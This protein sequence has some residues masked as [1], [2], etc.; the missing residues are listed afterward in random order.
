MNYKKYIIIPMV[1]TSL[2][3]MGSKNVSNNEKIE[4]IIT[5]PKNEILENESK[6][7]LVC[8]KNRINY[9]KVKGGTLIKYKFSFSNEGQDIVKIIDYNASCSCTILDNIKGSI[10]QPNSVFEIEMKINTKNKLKGTHSSNVT[11]ESTGQR[12]FNVLIVKYEI[13]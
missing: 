8:K 12:K 5:K 10:I 1:L 13:E 3:L 11:L 2:I 7:L 9:G 6:G 4:Q